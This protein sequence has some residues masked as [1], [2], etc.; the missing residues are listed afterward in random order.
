MTAFSRISLSRF[1]VALVVATIACGG[2]LA[3]LVTADTVPP[4]PTI[5]LQKAVHF[6]TAA[7]EDLVVAPGTYE[8]DAAKEGLRLKP[9]GG[10]ETEA[11]LVQAQ[12]LPHGESGKFQDRCRVCLS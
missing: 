4:T 7:G 5:A 6:L 10:K 11:V 9:T 8:V 3:S 1:R 2:T 12:A